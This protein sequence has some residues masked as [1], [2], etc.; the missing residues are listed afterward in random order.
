MK[1]G[2]GGFA[3]VAFGGEL[4]VAVRWRRSLGTS[5]FLSL[6]NDSRAQFH[7]RVQFQEE[8]FLTSP[9]VCS[10]KG[11]VMAIKECFL[12]VPCHKIGGKQAIKLHRLRD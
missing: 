4:A 11:C 2:D 3:G 12:P 7:R 9:A 1:L 5:P 6:E 8:V 10:P